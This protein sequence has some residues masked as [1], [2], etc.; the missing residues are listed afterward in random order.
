MIGMLASGAGYW[1]VRLFA[2]AE[3]KTMTREWQEATNEY[4]KE[5][6]VEP[7]TGFASEGYT[8]PGAIQ[9]K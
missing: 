1:F 3:P 2:N 6:K 7:I 9:S 4:L 8:G 5:A